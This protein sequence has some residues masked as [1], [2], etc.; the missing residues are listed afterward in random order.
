MDKSPTTDSAT[1][2]QVG[3][4]IKVQLALNWFPEIEH[5][6]YYEAVLK[7]YYEQAGLKVEIL[8]GGPD[9]PVIQRVGTERIAF[10]I[11]NADPVIFA[12][13]EQVPIVA[14]F[15]P[16]QH[17]PRCLVVHAASPVK[18]FDDLHDLTLAMNDSNAFAQYLR[19]KV[20]LTNVRI[21]RYSGSVAMFLADPNFVQQ[22]YNFSE[23]LIARQKGAQVR[24]LMLSDIGFDA[25]TSLLMTHDNYQ[26]SHPE[27]VQKM[28]AASRRGWESYLAQPEATNAYIHE[29]NP[30]IDLEILNAGTRELVP[31]CKMDDAPTGSP[32]PVYGSMEAT[33][34]TKLISQM[35]E[36]KVIASDVNIPAE[37]AITAESV[38]K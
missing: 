15:C 27:V 3:E 18:T 22:G 23:P 13:A 1:S 34:W 2:P 25:Y 12:R 5:G 20:P 7:G 16:I 10:G 26:K 6:G 38:A 36:A 14:L 21:V 33:R 24:N 35:K 31:L 8:P 9:A 29:L 32:A 4:L 19:F 37:I 30:E 28:I 11:A 17:S